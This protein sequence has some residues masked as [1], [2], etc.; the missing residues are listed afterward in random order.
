[1]KTKQDVLNLTCEVLGIPKFSVSTG[2][3]EPKEFFLA[4][5]E[6][7][8]INPSKM[9]GSKIELAK[10]IVESCG[11]PWKSDYES[12]GSTVTFGGL[13]AVLTSVEEFVGRSSRN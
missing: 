6:Q 7:L 12:T 8:G 3:T 4:V 9:P 11:R 1:M 13:C 10:L 5:I 2:S